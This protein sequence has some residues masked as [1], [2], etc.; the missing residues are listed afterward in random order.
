MLLLKLGN[1]TKH[2]VMI[3]AVIP[4]TIDDFLNTKIHSMM[5]IMGIHETINNN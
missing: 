1:I 4:V 3:S 2:P 5:M